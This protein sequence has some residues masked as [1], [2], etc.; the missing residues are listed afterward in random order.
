MGLISAKTYV[1][2]VALF[3]ITL[4]YFFLTNPM[5]LVDHTLVWVIG[6]SMGMPEE[7]SLESH[8]P[9]LAFMAVI[10]A[11]MGL[12]DLLTLSMPE[13]ACLVEHWGMQAPIRLLISLVLLA[14][15]FIFSPTSPIYR[16]TTPARGRLAHPDAHTLN[17][18]YVPS[19]WG[20][21]GLK[22]RAFFTFMFVEMACWFGL[23]V[24]LREERNDILARNARKR[25]VD[26]M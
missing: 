19:G 9:A 3:H 6:E 7:H 13:V 12:T 23:W 22:N 2:S 5:T 1:T 14:Y 24:T 4:A 26:M 8:S 11:I 10:L 15:T 20:G 18:G 21:D 16:D 25:G 17:P